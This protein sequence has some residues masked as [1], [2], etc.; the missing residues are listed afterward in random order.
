MNLAPEFELP[1][2]ECLKLPES[3][4][5]LPIPRDEW[6]RTLDDNVKNRL[7]DDSYHNRSIHILPI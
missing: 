4:Y 3:I 1:P 7:E 5:G 6:H 2:E